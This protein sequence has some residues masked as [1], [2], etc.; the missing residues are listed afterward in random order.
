MNIMAWL[1]SETIILEDEIAEVGC[2][3][4]EIKSLYSMTL[5]FDEDVDKDKPF[6]VRQKIIR[7]ELTV[8]LNL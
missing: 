1:E 3:I 4:K 6:F 7:E 5:Y 2:F 8:V